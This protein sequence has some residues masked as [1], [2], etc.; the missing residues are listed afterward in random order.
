[1][2]VYGKNV[3]KDINSKIEKVYVANNFKEK[4]ILK[5]IKAPIILHMAS[6]ITTT[7]F[8]PILIQNNLIINYSIFL[9]C[10]ILLIMIK[11]YTK[12]FKM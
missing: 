3:A 10:L 4:E 7:L 1:M 6:N 9:I 11:K 5:N 12:V 2:Y 8:L